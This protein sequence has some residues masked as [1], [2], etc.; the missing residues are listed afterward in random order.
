MGLYGD[1]ELTEDR[2]LHVFRGHQP[3]PTGEYMIWNLESCSNWSGMQGLSW[4]MNSQ[5]W[6]RR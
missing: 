1:G 2:E 3:S 6:S 5:V 4:D